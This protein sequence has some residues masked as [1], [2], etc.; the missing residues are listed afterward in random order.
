[1]P[2]PTF[3]SID[4]NCH[5]LWDTVP[6]LAALAAHGWT[7]LHCIE[8]I[9][10]AFSR[11][12][13]RPG[14]TGLALMRERF[15]RGGHSDWGAA[16]FCHDFLGR[17]P[18][19]VRALEP[20]TGR[21][22]AA[23]ARLLE[24][25]IDA[26]YDRW[27]ASDNWQLV[28]P[29][30]AEDP[31]WHRLIGDVT[32]AE[33]GPFVRQLLGHAEGDLLERFPEPGPQR[34][35]REWFAG[36]RALV[37]QILTAEPGAPL[38]ELYRRWLAT[39]P[40]GEVRLGLTSE[41]LALAETAAAD[42]VLRLFLTRYAEAA[43][44]YNAALERA[45]VGI[46]PL[47]TAEGELPFFV[48][49]RRGGRLLRTPAVLQDGSLRAAELS[50]PL[51]AG[52][53]PVG[54]MA[55]DG[56][57]ALAGKALVLVLQAR[58]GPQ[59][60]SLALP[61][62]GSLYMPAAHA[63]EQLLRER[64]LLQ[65]TPRPV[66]RVRFRFLDRWAGCRTLVRPPPYLQEALGL[67]EAP[68]ED[69]AEAIRAAMAAA[70]R[71]LDTWR[72]PSRREAASR[73][74]FAALA[75]ERDALEQDRRR[76]AADP[77]RRPEAGALWQRI[78][79]LDRRLAEAQAEWLQQQIRLLDLGYYDSRGALLPWCLALEGETL[80]GRLLQAADVAAETAPREPPPAQP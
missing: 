80:Y 21:T 25:S 67:A 16:L 49:A 5:P 19:D 66:L 54:A 27:S 57:V 50:W 36:Q 55:R 60:A 6:K 42:P 43:E 73:L 62:L 48:V 41:R 74:R 56:V 29:S 40:A 70:R 69:L 61:H 64:G 32:L 8:D 65:E 9:D 28:G 11:Q 38:T 71:E 12:G 37:G 47:R 59:G 23:L 4:Q 2:A 24:T 17:L 52:S 35:L 77:Q 68:A 34:R 46:A 15:Y 26:L 51:G 18:F 20:F 72:D 3:I 13:A 7:G 31:R 79:Q 14:E 45:P 76:A 10:L 78:K 63:L 1:M 53:L 30:Y 58:T 39:I 75:A 44:A 22:T 33:A